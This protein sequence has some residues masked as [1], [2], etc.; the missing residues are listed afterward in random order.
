MFRRA[1]LCECL[2]TDFRQ[3]FSDNLIQAVFTAPESTPPST[4]VEN[5]T[6]RVVQE[7]TLEI[8]WSFEGSSQV[9]TFMYGINFDRYSSTWL[10][11]KVIKV[12]Y[13]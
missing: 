10:L 7:H 8:F 4:P 9:C 11:L 12:F 1:V 5:A 13:S 2:L 3:Y 6:G